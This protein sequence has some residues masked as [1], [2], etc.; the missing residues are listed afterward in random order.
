LEDFLRQN[1]SAVFALIGALGGSLISYIGSFLLKKRE[2]NLQLWGK[3]IDK[4]IEAHENVIVI[5]LEMRVM[6]ALGGFDNDGELRRAPQV[7]ISKEE[8]DRWFTRFTQ[9]TLRGTTWLTTDAKRE[10]NFVHDYLV[11]LHLNLSNIASEKFLLVG[12]VVRQDFLD[13]SSSLEKNSFGYF[14]D[15][16]NTLKLDSLEKWHKYERN[17]TDARLGKTKLMCNFDQIR[18]IAT[19]ST[20]PAV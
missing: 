2:F 8:F 11:N 9:L 1:T 7:L 18:I 20:P 10:L 3:L 12:E 6:V 14:E 4:R 15:G 17:V 16:I 13:L 5:A 19:N